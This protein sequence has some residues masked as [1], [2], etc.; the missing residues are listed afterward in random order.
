M[1]VISNEHFEV[2]IDVAYN[3]IEDQYGKALPRSIVRRAISQAFVVLAIDHPG[4]SPTNPAPVVEGESMVHDMEPKPVEPHHSLNERVAKLERDNKSIRDAI[5]WHTDRY[6]AVTRELTRIMSDLSQ[7]VGRCEG[8]DTAF[9]IRLDGVEATVKTMW[10]RV[11]AAETPSQPTPTEPEPGD[12]R[13]QWREVYDEFVFSVA[14]PQQ[15]W[16]YT[17]D[18]MERDDNTM[19]ITAMQSAVAKAVEL[20]LVR[21]EPVVIEVTREDVET[22]WDDCKLAIGGGTLR[23]ILEAYAARLRLRQ[24]G[25]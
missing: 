23:L 19:W 18:Q 16:F 2:A 20:G 5:M 7:K 15:R 24:E 14:V 17:S 10:E 4:W 6:D 13:R 9:G 11:Y 12:N 21:R 8:A 22:V 3:D 25:V 1:T